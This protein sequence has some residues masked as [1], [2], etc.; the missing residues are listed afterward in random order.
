MSAHTPGPWKYHADN[1]LAAW[2]VFSEATAKD[3]EDIASVWLKEDDARLIAA[4]PE[5]A[6]ALHDCIYGLKGWMEKAKKA[7][8][9]ATG[10]S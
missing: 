7:Y 9:K 4:A 3:G 6:K 10:A 1:V 5:M 8:D 2:R